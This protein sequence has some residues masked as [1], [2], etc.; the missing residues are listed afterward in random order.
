MFVFVWSQICRSMRKSL[1]FRKSNTFQSTFSFSPLRTSLASFKITLWIPEAILLPSV[2]NNTKHKYKL[3]Q[4]IRSLQRLT[5]YN[6]PTWNAHR[7]KAF[8]AHESDTQ[9]LMSLI[10]MYAVHLMCVVCSL[11]QWPEGLLPDG[12]YSAGWIQICFFFGIR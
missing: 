3:P 6:A 10:R 4:K 11:W 9:T 12:N 8:V 2:D 7:L 1:T 5:N